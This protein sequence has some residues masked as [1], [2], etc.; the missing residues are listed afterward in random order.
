MAPLF[1]LSHIF[2]TFSPSQLAKVGGGRAK[3]PLPSPCPDI[4]PSKRHASKPSQGDCPTLPGLGQHIYI[5]PKSKRRVPFAGT[6][7]DW[8]PRDAP[9]FLA[10]NGGEEHRTELP[11]RKASTGRVF[12]EREEGLPMVLSSSTTIL[13][14]RRLEASQR[15]RK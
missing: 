2:Q 3:D 12:P 8:T 9:S 7:C 1:L 4:N 14:R 15:G 6:P 13:E 11:S 5:C 10:R